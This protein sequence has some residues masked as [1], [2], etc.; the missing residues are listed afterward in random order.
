MFPLIVP[1]II[2][3]LA[4]SARVHESSVVVK[5]LGRI[6]AWDMRFGNPVVVSKTFVKIMVVFSLTK[7]TL[8]TP[9]TGCSVGPMRILCPILFSSRS[10]RI[11]GSPVI[12]E[13]L[14]ESRIHCVGRV[15]LSV[16]VRVWY[17]FVSSDG[18]GVVTSSVLIWLCLE[19]LSRLL[20]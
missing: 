10:N 9:W 5:V 8:P 13:L 2:T 20:F 11:V 1:L 3:F 16:S 19:L 7:R 18:D 17:T 15:F 6:F 14:P 12:C 4:L